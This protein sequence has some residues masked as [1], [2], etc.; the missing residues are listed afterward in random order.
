MIRSH[1]DY[2]SYLEAD[3]IAMGRSGKPPKLLVKDP[4]W[5]YQRLLRK[6]EYTINCLTAPIYLP[7]RMWMTY[8]YLSVKLLLGFQIPA[9]VVGPG[10][11]LVHT[12]DILI[13]DRVKIGNNLRINIGVVIGMGADENAVPVIGSNVIIEPGAKIYGAI[14]IADWTHIGA[15]AVVNKSVTEPGMVVAGVPARIIKPN[16]HYPLP[17]EIVSVLEEQPLAMRVPNADN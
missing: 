15:N 4:T 11:N 2:L 16:P 9:N 12:G 5:Y 17:R 7:L 10:L 14:T 3:R 6:Y 13:N 1:A 8:R